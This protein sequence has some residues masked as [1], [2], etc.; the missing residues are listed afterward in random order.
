M[1]WKWISG[2]SGAGWAAAVPAVIPSAETTMAA[3]AAPVRSIIVFQLPILLSGN[4][5]S[6]PTN[7]SPTARGKFPA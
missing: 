4:A 2:V 7:K 6:L 5:I 3:I 1:A